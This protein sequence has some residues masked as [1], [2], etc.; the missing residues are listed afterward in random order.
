MNDGYEFSIIN[1]F[2][3]AYV[4]LYIFG[5]ILDF[6]YNT[7]LYSPWVAL[8]L[9]IFLLFNVFIIVSKEVTIWAKVI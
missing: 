4:S 3:G 2:L 8:L 9:L 1:I 6:L 7:F 5:F